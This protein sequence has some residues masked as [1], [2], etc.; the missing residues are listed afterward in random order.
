VL[1]VETIQDRQPEK[2]HSRGLDNDFDI[3]MENVI[4]IV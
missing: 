3:D 4:D 2:A 1:I